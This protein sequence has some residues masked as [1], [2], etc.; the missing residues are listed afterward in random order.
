MGKKPIKEFLMHIYSKKV[1]FSIILLVVLSIS[2]AFFSLVPAYLIKVIFD[3]I[4]VSFK[5]NLLI[6]IIS[7]LIVFFVA[8]SALELFNTYFY[9]KLLN[10]TTQ[11]YRTKF[12]SSYLNKD[13]NAIADYSE[14]DIIYR[15]N[16]DVQN[17]CELSF[18]LIVKTFTQS[19]FLFGLLYIMFRSSAILTFCVLILMGIEYLYNYLA[20]N[21]LR[22]KIDKVKTSDSNLLEA[23]KQM[24]SR[25]I[26]IRLNKLQEKEI[27]RF[28]K[29]LFEALEYKKEY[30]INQS[31]LAGVSS[32][33]SGLRQMI[34]IVVGA[35]LI[36][37]GEMTIGLLIAFNQLT[38]SVSSPA[39]Y[40][41][42]IIHHYKNLLSSFERT[43]KIMNNNAPFHLSTAV[44]SNI[45]L[46]CNG[47]N[48]SM[49]NNHLIQNLNLK[50]F[51]KESVAIIGESGSGKSTLCKLI[52]GLYDYKGEIYLQECNDADRATVGFMLD[53]STMFRGSLWENITYGLEENSVSFDKVKEVLQMVKLEYLIEQT[54]QFRATVDKNILSKG[55]KQRLEL[56]RIIL[57]KPALIILDEP[58][59]GLDDVTEEFVWKNFRNECCNSTILFTTH[60]RE[61]IYARDRIL[62]MRKGILRE[63]EIIQGNL[64]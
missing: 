37:K 26:Y 51:S 57:L 61:L 28:K 2:L 49:N 46:V 17:I 3:E 39:N 24:I 34:V 44:D 50:V 12:L 19:V 48:F 53:E 62:E 23:Y 63:Q 4:S 41:S 7:I 27:T 58:T 25:Y 10:S 9:V 59:S 29:V 45:K 47:V 11:I 5:L 60:K 54:D 32:I 31:F 55:E 15:G 36:S 40:F 64:A 14:G 38:Q 16:S 30:I 8:S 33:I 43:E 20:S 35:Y 22:N 21:K 13:Y 1:L 6:K 42:N 52:A 56:A 18:E